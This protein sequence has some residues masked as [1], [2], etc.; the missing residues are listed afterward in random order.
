[1]PFYVITKLTLQTCDVCMAR[2][3][4][5]RMFCF[6]LQCTWLE[7]KCADEDFVRSYTETGLC[8]TFNG[9]TLFFDHK[10]FVNIT[11]DVPDG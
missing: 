10:L 5:T 1:M 9:S 8:L 2:S 7:S 4:C 3:L 11:W 6:Y